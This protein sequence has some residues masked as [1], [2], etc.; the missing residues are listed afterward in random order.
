MEFHEGRFT[1]RVDQPETVHP[2]TFH[3]AKGPRDGAIRHHPHDH[4]HAF[5]RER[6]EIPEIVMRGLRLRESAIRL[7]L[8]RMDEV[9]ELDWILDEED[10]NIIADNVPIAL[11]GIKF[12]R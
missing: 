6:D 11:F 8:Y 5:R 7:F 4:V 2:E 12:H 10:G 1:V 3:E 9:R